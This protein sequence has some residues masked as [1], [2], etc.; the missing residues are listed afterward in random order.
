MDGTLFQNLGKYNFNGKDRTALITQ[1]P[2]LKGW[3]AHSWYIFYNEMVQTCS[4]NKCWLL[5]Y[6]MVVDRNVDGFSIGETEY[7]ADCDLPVAFG[8]QVDIWDNVIYNMITQE[9]V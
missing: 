2:R 5:P 8:N 6:K 7:D 9:N 3:D 1:A 4:N